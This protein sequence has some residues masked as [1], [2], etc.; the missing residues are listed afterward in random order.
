MHRP[1]Q[2]FVSWMEFYGCF[3]G[4]RQRHLQPRQIWQ[5]SNN[6]FLGP[7]NS[8][9]EANYVP[10]LCLEKRNKFGAARI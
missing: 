1:V 5:S 4:R 10:W 6:L 9:K 7:R 3:S 2:R 8:T